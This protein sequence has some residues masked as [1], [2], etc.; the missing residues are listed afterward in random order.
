M[1]SF[2]GKRKTAKKRQIV[3]IFRNVLEKQLNFCARNDILKTNYPLMY[4]KEEKR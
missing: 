4:I 1:F 2:V 3:H